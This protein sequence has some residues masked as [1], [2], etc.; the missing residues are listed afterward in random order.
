MRCCRPYRI[1]LAG[2]VWHLI[3]QENRQ[4]IKSF[5]TRDGPSIYAGCAPV[6]FNG[7]EQMQIRCSAPAVFKRK[8]EMVDGHMCQISSVNRIWTIS[9]GN[10]LHMKQDKSVL[11]HTHTGTDETTEPNEIAEI[12]I[13]MKI[14][15]S[16]RYT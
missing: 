2:A 6:V 3:S 1:L 5:G 12:E 4:H 16:Q 14:S 7:D 10:T 9:I 13:H 15:K 11:T 8:P